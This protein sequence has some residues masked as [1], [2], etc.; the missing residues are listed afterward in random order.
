[1][2]QVEPWLQ[3]GLALVQMVSLP[4]A[5]QASMHEPFWAAAPSAVHG[6]C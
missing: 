5:Q 4:F 3:Q 2:K 6:H 1:M